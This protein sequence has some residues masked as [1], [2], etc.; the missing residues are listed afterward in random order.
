MKTY[1]AYLFQ[2]QGCDYTIGCGET[3]IDVPANSMEE[4]K[5]KLVEIIKEEYSH[6]ERQLESAK[7]FE[8]EQSFDIDMKS[9][10]NKIN[11]DREIKSKQESIERE[12]VEFERLKAKFG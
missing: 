1:K 11:E 9:I 7:I 3:I 10:Y 8:V 6:E 2:G 4:A 5:K 12:R